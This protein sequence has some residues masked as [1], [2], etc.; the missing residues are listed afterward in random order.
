MQDT[1]VISRRKGHG[2]PQG[3]ETGGD[4]MIV[5]KPLQNMQKCVVFF[6]FGIKCFLKHWFSITPGVSDLPKGHV[7]DIPAEVQ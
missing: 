6:S 3:L 1:S 4:I 7:H 5:L 2:R